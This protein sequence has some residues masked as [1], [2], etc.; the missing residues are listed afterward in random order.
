MGED[1]DELWAAYSK[2]QHLNHL[3]ERVVWAM[4]A[5]KAVSVED[6]PDGAIA[7]RLARWRA[8]SLEA[9]L[10]ARTAW[11]KFARSEGAKD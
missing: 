7:V 3:L 1:T 2:A 11:Q 10:V 8:R 6:G 4:E 5:L 9:A